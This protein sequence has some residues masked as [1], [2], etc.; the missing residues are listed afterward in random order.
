MRSELLRTLILILLVLNAVPMIRINETIV[1]DS[2][3]GVSILAS[4]KTDNVTRLPIAIISLENG[5][6]INCSSVDEALRQIYSGIIPAN[7]IRSVNISLFGNYYEYL[8]NKSS[9]VEYTCALKVFFQKLTPEL[10]KVYS[11]YSGQIVPVSD[12]EYLNLVYGSYFPRIALYG[13]I[14]YFNIT[15]FDPSNNTTLIRNIL[16]G[17]DSRIFLLIYARIEVDETLDI[18]LN[19]AQSLIERFKSDIHTLVIDTT[20]SFNISKYLSNKTLPKNVSIVWDNQTIVLAGKNG[21]LEIFTVN[22]TNAEPLIILLDSSGLV[23]FKTYGI[24]PSTELMIYIS[25]YLEKGV[26]SLPIYPILAVVAKDPYAGKPCKVYVIPGTGF[27][28][29]TE[30]KLSYALLDSENKTIYR[31][32][33]PISISPISLS[34][35]IE[36]LDNRTRWILVNA[37]IFSTYGSYSSEIFAYRVMYKEE[38][39][40]SPIELVAPIIYAII[41]LVVI[42]G[43]ALRVYR[44][45]FKIKK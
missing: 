24:V 14:S 21:S 45:Y 30:V 4:N 44:K 19:Y 17:A 15:T 32:S 22:S 43:I 28:N 12:K 26:F 13:R 8:S 34:Y 3:K 18:I 39:E 40:V 27:G 16:E 7:A 31:T 38:K 33:K 41:S 11:N 35:T 9:S 1:V 6:L 20:N 5:S 29:I 42:F 23:W 2:D 36:S 10:S 37:T 25:M